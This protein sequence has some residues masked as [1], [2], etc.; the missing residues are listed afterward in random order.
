M[1]IGVHTSATPQ[2]DTGERPLETS[3]NNFERNQLDTF[4]IKVKVRP[5]G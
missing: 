2:G 1:L 4:V 3:S 5:T